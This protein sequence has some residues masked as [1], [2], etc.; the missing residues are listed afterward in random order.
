MSEAEKPYNMEPGDEGIVAGWVGRQSWQFAW[1]RAIAK[2]WQDEDYRT[3][4]LSSPEK[5]LHEFGFKFP[6]GLIIKIV[7]YSGSKQYDPSQGKNGWGHM[8]DELAGE[9]TMVLPPTPETPLQASA[10]AD[11]NATGVTYPF[12][13]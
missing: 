5:A 10:L 7:E 9:V 2:A 8:Y 1:A 6:K 12:T 13:T 3:L 4:L 11:Y